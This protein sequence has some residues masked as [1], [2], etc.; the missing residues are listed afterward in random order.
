MAENLIGVI[1]G[2]G[3]Y[4]MEGFDLVEEKKVSTPFGEPSDKIIIGKLGSKQVAFLPRHGRGHKYSPSVINYRANICALKMLGVQQII[5][6]SAVGSLKEG[7]A[8]G[9]LVIVDQF[10]DR[11][12]SRANTFFD[13]GI[14]AHISFAHPVCERLAAVV[15]DSAKELG[16]KTHK[17]GTYLCMEGPQFSTKAESFLHKNLG[18]DLIGM[19]NA[20][21]A[22]LVREAEICY[23]TIALSTDYDCWKDDEHVNVK[24][25]LETMKKN[26]SNAQKVIRTTIEKMSEKRDCACAN[27]L[28]GAIMTDKKMISE[29]IRKRMEPIAG[30]Y[31]R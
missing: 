6:V 8:P 7:I 9:D 3:L 27:A 12:R 20:T 28:M 15:Y 2:S 13:G 25:I 1:G 18:A 29:D 5:S 19:T 11:T 17:K 26:V 4:N 14:V 10:I 24:A 22:K 16:I 21:E 31:F 30:K 23:S